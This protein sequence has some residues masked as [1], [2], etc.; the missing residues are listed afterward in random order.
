MLDVSYIILLYKSIIYQPMLSYIF[1]YSNN[2]SI[3]INLYLWDKLIKNKIVF[4][5][6]HYI[7]LKF[8][9]KKIIIENDV[10]LLFSLFKNCN[11]YQYIEELGYYSNRNNTGSIFN[12]RNDLSKSNEIIYS[13]F[14]NIEFLYDKEEKTIFS[15]YFCIFKLLQGY[16]R[17]INCFKYLN[18]YTL[19]K[20]NYILKKLLKS[21]YIT[22]NDKIFIKNISHQISLAHHIILL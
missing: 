8:L 15:K 20:V 19:K 2:N 16:N 17:Y 21:N 12:T 4:K 14:S 5:A 1:Y 18:H 10:V 7:G 11:S 22:L 6:L 9:H 3:E 13:I